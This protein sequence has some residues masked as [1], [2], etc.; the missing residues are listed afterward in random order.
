MKVYTNFGKLPDGIMKHAPEGYVFERTITDDTMP[1]GPIQRTIK[2][3]A[4]FDR[5]DREKD[6][7]TAWA[8]FEKKYGKAEDCCDK[9]KTT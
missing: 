9:E 7:E 4:P 2:Y 1:G 6:Y 3:Y 8:F 5:C